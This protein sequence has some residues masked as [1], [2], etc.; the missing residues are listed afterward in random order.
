MRNAYQL[1][2]STLLFS[3]PLHDRL[4]LLLLIHFHRL[5]PIL[6]LLLHLPF[7][8]LLP[9]SLLLR[10]H[11]LLPP[12]PLPPPP[13]L[14]LPPSPL[15]IRPLYRLAILLERILGFVPRIATHAGD[16]SGVEVVGGRAGVGL[17][18][19]GG[20]GG[21]NGWWWWVRGSGGRG[22]GGGGW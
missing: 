16:G 20:G 7:P 12:P 2:K 14:H 22:G 19:E 21:R 11:L 5:P 9:F 8:F 13:R 1:V 15:H 18:A 10:P 4:L 6:S 3:L 17:A